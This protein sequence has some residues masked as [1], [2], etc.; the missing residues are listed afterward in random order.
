MS[1]L[2]IQVIEK[3][4]TIPPDNSGHGLVVLHGFVVLCL[5]YS[6][7]NLIMP[8]ELPLDVFYGDFM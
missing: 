6:C 1:Y 3:N 2:T 8:D 7:I 5:K 4:R